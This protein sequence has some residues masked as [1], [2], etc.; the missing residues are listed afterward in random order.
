LRAKRK[1]K[2]EEKVQKKTKQ[3][4]MN[5]EENMIMTQKRLLEKSPSHIGTNPLLHFLS[6]TSCTK[7]DDFQWSICRQLAPD[8]YDDLEKLTQHMKE[9]KER[10]EKEKQIQREQQEKEKQ[11]QR[12]QQREIKFLNKSL[13]VEE[14]E[15]IRKN[16]PGIFLIQMRQYK[17]LMIRYKMISKHV[18]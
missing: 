16:L 3:K 1:E 10:K 17:T 11:I 8:I 7:W 2:R 6:N 9:R 14:T 18:Y 5:E 4:K 15:E 13:N 12:E